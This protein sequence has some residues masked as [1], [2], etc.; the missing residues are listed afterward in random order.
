MFPALKASVMKLGQLLGIPDSD[1]WPQSVEHAYLGIFNILGYSRKEVKKTDPLSGLVI[2]E[3]V[4]TY[5]WPFRHDIYKV[6][7]KVFRAVITLFL[8]YGMMARFSDLIKIQAKHVRFLK[9][10]EGERYL[11][12]QFHNAKNNKNR[13]SMTGCIMDSDKLSY[14][15]VKLVALYFKYF[16]LKP[17]LTDS[18]GDDIPLLHR[19][20]DHWRLKTPQYRPCKETISRNKSLEEIRELCKDFGFTGKVTHISPKAGAVT[21]ALEGGISLENCAL[22]G[23]WW[24]TSTVSHYRRRYSLAKVELGKGV[25]PGAQRKKK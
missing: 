13:E 23:R 6:E 25:M 12:F 17:T 18:E 22:L 24:N 4:L 5:I 11:E 1:V 2:E 9:T 19:F 7:A 21:E 3:L 15:P 10:G 8:S 16:N 20:Q 14:S